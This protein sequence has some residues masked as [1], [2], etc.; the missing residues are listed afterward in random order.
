VAENGFQMSKLQ[1]RASP[2]VLP[3]LSARSHRCQGGHN[4]GIVDD[5]HHQFL[6]KGFSLASVAGKK[7]TRIAKKERKGRPRG[8]PFAS[9]KNQQLKQT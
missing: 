6:V 1:K 9:A 5:F 3:P 2:P 8:Q 4:Y 7:P